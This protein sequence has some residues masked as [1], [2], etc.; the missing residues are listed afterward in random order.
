M[1]NLS[2]HEG[3]V[4]DARDM[5]DWKATISTMTFAA[6]EQSK[7]ILTSGPTTITILGAF[8]SLGGGETLASFP[9]ETVVT[10]VTMVSTDLS[11]EYSLA[12]TNTTLGAL[13]ASQTPYDIISPSNVNVF[14]G[15]SGADWIVGTAGTDII[16][17]GKADDILQG[18][19]G[20]DSLYGGAGVN[21]ARYSGLLSD[22]IVA[23]EGNGVYR[24][25]DQRDGWP[26]GTDRVDHIQKLAFAD[27]QVIDISDAVTDKFPSVPTLSNTTI[28]ENLPAGTVVGTLSSIDPEG[29]P[30]TY[31][32]LQAY[33]QEVE[34]WYEYYDSKDFGVVDGK[35]VALRAFDFEKE[36]SFSLQ[37]IAS[38]RGVH[39]ISSTIAITVKDV[40]D[41]IIGTKYRDTIVGANLNDTIEGL[42]T[43]DK[44][45]GLG[46]NDIIKGG[47]GNDRIEGGLGADD[48]YGGTESDTFI[49]RDVRESTVALFGRDTIVDFTK[50]DVVNLQQID[51]NT[52][53]AGGQAFHFIGTDAF[54]GEAGELRFKKMASDTYIYADTNGDKKSDFSIHLDDAISL[55][56]GFFVL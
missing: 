7:L 26:D 20:S 22:Y 44:L 6:F 46:G 11:V 33:E 43:G 25:I 51:A 32:V 31:K 52:K 19:E 8:N 27:G 35:L 17:G 45:I 41:A 37:I 38:D 23:D 49:Y 14:A 39:E 13:L 2:V 36:K 5:S 42:A 54:S 30:I 9:A 16:D 28:A 50:S 18:N 24:V 21:T 47:S 53:M 34:G 3:A 55:S 12:G 15:L 40:G 4:F 48:L 29:Q 10:G 56:K 1:A